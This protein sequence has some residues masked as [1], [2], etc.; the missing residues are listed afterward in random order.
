MTVVDSKTR[1]T[2]NAGTHASLRNRLWRYGPLVLW[3]AVIFI[4]SGAELSAANTS[5]IVRPLLLWLFPNISEHGLTYAHFLI[6]KS[7]HFIEYAVLALLAW[8]AAIGSSKGWLRHHGFAAALF[9]G[10]L[11]SI[12]DEYRQSLLPSRTGSIYDGAIDIAGILAA[13]A[14]I[15]AWHKIA[16]WWAR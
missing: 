15:V 12:V 4:A 14:L 2:E 11:V 13:L 7:G 8:R 16:S 1:E 5:R 9:L 10:I 3:I 6:R